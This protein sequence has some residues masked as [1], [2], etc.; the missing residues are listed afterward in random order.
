MKRRRLFR[1]FISARFTVGLLCL[2]AVLLLL[3]VALP[4]ESVLGEERYAA[5][6][7]RSG[8][9]TRLL[10]E[11][12]GFG[13]MA[14]SPVFLAVLGLFFLNLAAVLLAR[15]KPTWHR[16]G[17][18][19]RSEKGLRAWARM[20]ET[21]SGPLPE[22]WSAARIVHVLRGH[23]YRV[24]RPGKE[25]FWAVKHRTAPLGFL[26]FHLSFFLLS[27]GG[28]AIYYTRFV[29]TA[30]VSEGQ[31]FSG[32]YSTIV[33]TAPL[34]GPPPLRFAVEEIEA[35][36]ENGQ[37]VQLAAR[38]RFGP[39]G[40]GGARQSR[41]NHPA[42]WGAASILVERAGLAPVLWLQDESGFTLDRVVVPARTFA[43]V[44]TEVAMAEGEWQATVY[45]LLAGEPFPERSELAE[46]G[47]DIELW[48]GDE[49]L[50]SGELRAGEAASFDGGRLVMEELRYWVGLRVIRER[51]GGLLIVGFTLGIIGLVWR[52]LWYRREIALT[53]EDDVFRL[54]GRSEYFSAP[55]EAELASLARMLTETDGVA[56]D[57]R[58]AP[59]GRVEA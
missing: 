48:R 21:H 28:A 40:A 41:V 22:D 47:L 29:G 10:L 17:L 12:L 5:M 46:T 45:P 43:T 6:L 36:M 44:T 50:F 58:S 55:F 8:G 59:N 35:R 13:R 51:G 37:P 7:E 33:R 16:V 18:K 34:G 20:E 57:R 49:E 32:D 56:A 31:T 19:P 39:A 42:R 24:R 4:Q 1:R 38:L 25:T 15:L 2:L 27:A 53:W 14:T 54:V 9:G 3:N 23:G 30:I 11:T 26:L 52:L